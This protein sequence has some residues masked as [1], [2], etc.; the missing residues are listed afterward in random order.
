MKFDAVVAD[1][2]WTFRDQGRRGGTKRHYK[3][4]PLSEIY[5]LA[6]LVSAVAGPAAH[7]YLWAPNALV[8]DGTAQEVARRWGW[9]PFQLLTWL[10]PKM[11]TGMMF[12]NTTEQAVFC[13]RPGQ[14]LKNHRRSRSLKSHFY[15]PRS[16][17][18]EKPPE[19]YREVVERMSRGPYLDLFARYRRPGWTCV[20]NEIDGLDVRQAL[21][22]LA[23]A[24]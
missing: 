2:P 17:H 3:G 15:W 8:L 5:G 22:Q 14:L 24:A 4:M 16:E 19:F 12:R 18:S 7:L 13:V 9:H 21:G 1:N 20:G 11:G 23:R 10:K 6:D